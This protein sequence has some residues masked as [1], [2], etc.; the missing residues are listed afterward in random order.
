LKLGNRVKI[1]DDAIIP[2]RKITDYLL[3]YRQHDDKSLF[4]AQAGFSRERPDSLINAIRTLALSVEATEDGHNEYG[5]FLRQEG[6]LTGTNGHL[7][8]VVLIWLKWHQDGS[9]HFITLKPA[10][11]KNSYEY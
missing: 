7:L 10:K 5:T 8:L 9:V 6:N 2:R 4:L 3:E 11:E 1:P